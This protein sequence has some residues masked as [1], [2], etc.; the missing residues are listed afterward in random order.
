[1]KRGANLSGPRRAIDSGTAYSETIPSA[2]RHVF[3]KLVAPPRISLTNRC[4]SCCLNGRFIEI[5]AL[6]V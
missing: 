3:W 5:V 6:Q 1:M 4:R 2:A